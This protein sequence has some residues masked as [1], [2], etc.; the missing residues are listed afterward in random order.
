MNGSLMMEGMRE[1]GYRGTPMVPM[2]LPDLVAYV[3]SIAIVIFLW[4]Q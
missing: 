1:A 2:S 3:A 4:L